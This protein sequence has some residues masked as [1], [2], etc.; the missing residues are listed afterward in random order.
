MFSYGHQYLDGHPNRLLA[1]DVHILEVLARLSTSLSLLNLYN[2]KTKQ[3]LYYPLSRRRGSGVLCV[4]ERKTR[5][6]LESKDKDKKRPKMQDQDGHSGFSALHERQ[7]LLS[8]ALKAP[9]WDLTL[10]ESYTLFSAVGAARPPWGVLLKR[11][12]VVRS[13][14]NRGSNRR[15]DEKLW[16]LSRD[17]SF[18]LAAT[19]ENTRLLPPKR[20]LYFAKEPGKLRAELE[21]KF[22][23]TFL[24]P[25]GFHSSFLLDFIL[26]WRMNDVYCQ[27][28][29]KGLIYFSLRIF[30]LQI[31]IKLF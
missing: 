15:V 30:E 23:I 20:D 10:R 3:L 13:I 28:E 5:I 14:W 24:L 2:T 7:L 26:T 9:K 8:E 31:N 4:R 6:E 19:H 11:K 16:S 17:P 22:Q 1:I 12:R 29:K 21:I 18:T 25:I 27:E